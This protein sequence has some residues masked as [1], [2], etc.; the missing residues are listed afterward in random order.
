M[1]QGFGRDEMIAIYGLV[2]GIPYYLEQ[3]DSRLSFE[4][5]IRAKYLDPT[6]VIAGE[7]ELMFLAEFRKPAAYLSVIHAISK[8]RRTP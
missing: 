7:P 1:L 3:F 8:G 2:G 5:N 6:C 4:D